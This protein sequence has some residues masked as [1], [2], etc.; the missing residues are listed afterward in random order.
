MDVLTSC[1]PKERRQKDATDCGPCRGKWVST[2]K[3]GPLQ[4]HIVF[5]GV[6]APSLLAQ[7]PHSAGNPSATSSRHVCAAATCWRAGPKSGCSFHPCQR[8][9]TFVVLL[10]L[11]LVR[12]RFSM[13]CAFQGSLK[14]GQN[15]NIHDDWLVAKKLRR[16]RLDG[17]RCVQLGAH[18]LPAA[19]FCAKGRALHFAAS[20]G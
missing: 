17:I 6:A 16:F 12:T 1:E 14:M 11:R 4:C 15:Q 13:I 8:V 3:L 7:S 10:E 5:V 20:R 9:G 18:L 19:S 2:I